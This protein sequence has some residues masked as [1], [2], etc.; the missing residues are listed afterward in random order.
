MEAL[1]TSSSNKYILMYIIGIKYTLQ[2][3]LTSYNFNPF[4]KMPKVNSSSNKVVTQK[5]EW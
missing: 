3:E 5:D 4:K 2:Y 1:I